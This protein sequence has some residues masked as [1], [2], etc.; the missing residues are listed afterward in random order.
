MSVSWYLILIDNYKIRIS[1]DISQKLRL[2]NTLYVFKE[3]KL[4][5]IANTVH[6][7]F[8]YRTA[9]S[10]ESVIN[11]FTLYYSPVIRFDPLSHFYSCQSN[12]GTPY[13][14]PRYLLSTAVDLP[15]NP[16]RPLPTANPRIR[17]PLAV[18]R[19]PDLRAHEQTAVIANSLA[20]SKV[21]K[22]GRRCPTEFFK[23]V[24]HHLQ[25]SPVTALGVCE[26]EELVQGQFLGIVPSSFGP[27]RSV[28]HYALLQ[29]P[30]HLAVLLV[31]GIYIGLR[32]TVGPQEIS[33]IFVPRYLACGKYSE[34]ITL[35]HT[36]RLYFGCFRFFWVCMHE[37]SNLRNFVTAQS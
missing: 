35:V 20:K 30:R 27:S 34:L 28:P 25:E 33:V 24:L 1:Q 2:L 21:K 11:S 12:V 5:N 18:R 32:K 6:R 3:K 10:P 13:A 8:V 15:V 36:T 9:K 37:K 26:G 16:D 7:L 29:R 31:V 4:H 17:L 23:E 19:R 22:Y 14:C